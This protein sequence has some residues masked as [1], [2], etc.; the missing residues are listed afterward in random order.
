MAGNKVSSKIGLRQFFLRKKLKVSDILYGGKVVRDIIL[1]L[2]L[3]LK[4]ID[5]YQFKYCRRTSTLQYTPGLN[6]SSITKNYFYMQKITN[7][8]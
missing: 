6:E 5:W 8:H 3:V 7:P 1:V 2:F 4:K